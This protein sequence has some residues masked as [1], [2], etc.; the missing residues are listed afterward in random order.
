M[1]HS[2]KHALSVSK[3]SDSQLVSVV[4]SGSLLSAA[5]SYELQ[6]RKASKK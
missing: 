1:A 3:M 4:A 5:A 2:S 6:K